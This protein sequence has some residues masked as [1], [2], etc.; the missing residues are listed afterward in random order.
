MN[1]VKRVLLV[2]IA[3]ILVFASGC[4]ATSKSSES[5]QTKFDIWWGAWT[6]PLYAAFGIGIAIYV[7][8]WMYAS[9]VQDDKLKVWV[10]SELIQL[11]Y[12]AVIVI[13]IMAVISAVSF[14]AA[15]IPA[16]ASMKWDLGAQWSDYVWARCEDLNVEPQRP[17]HI[18]MAEDYLEI[19][20]KSTQAQAT[21]ILRYVSV[22]FPISSIGIGFRAIPAP[23]GALSVSPFG[24]LT[25]TIDTLSFVF[26]MLMK[27]MIAIRAQQ[28][29]IDF[30]HVAFF[31][32][33]LAAGV[34]FRTFYFTRKLGGL[35]IALAIGFYIVLP[36]MYVF[37]AS[38]LFSFTGPWLDSVSGGII[39]DSRDI[40]TG[41]LVTQYSFGDYNPGAVQPVVASSAYYEPIGSQY[42][43]SNGYSYRGQ[44][45]GDGVIDPWE[46]CGEADTSIDA[47]TKKEY[48]GKPF[49]CKQ[50][51]ICDTNACKCTEDFYLYEGHGDFREDFEASL[52]ENSDGQS[53]LDKRATLIADM[54][55][56]NTV[57]NNDAGDFLE[58]TYKSWYERLGLGYLGAFVRAG[59]TDYLL[60]ANGTIDNAAKLMVFSLIAP[61]ISLMV[62]LGTVKVLSP[63][64]G[65]DVEIAGLT[66][67]I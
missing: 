56:D 12:S 21:S 44:S 33:M 58:I 6:L 60:G 49:V 54:C 38:V 14:L 61:F 42:P 2:A 37:W 29:A 64:L 10:K 67:L 62:A 4:I 63:T 47:L 20:A 17:C 3:A 53:V 52:I 32:Y 28:F 48:Y 59:P 55:A 1:N 16:Y 24:G 13:F 7:I 46:E 18:R 39:E 19:L 9:F 65:G 15:E 41:M 8:S 5:I 31:P 50:G 11:G 27:N 26:N 23:G 36:L 25:P 40:G 66:R 43:N 51:E 34:F 30:M 57:R 45:C 35:F 22:L